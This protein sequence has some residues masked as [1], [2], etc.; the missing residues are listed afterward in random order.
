MSLTRLLRAAFLTAVAAAVGCFYAAKYV[1]SNWAYGVI[2]SI[3]LAVLLSPWLGSWQRNR[4]RN[5]D[6]LDSWPAGIGDE[7]HHDHGH[8][9]GGDDAGHGG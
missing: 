3:L 5:S 9:G 7:T 1:D 6:G 4:P 8:G 2:G